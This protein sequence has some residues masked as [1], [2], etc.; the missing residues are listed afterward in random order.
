MNASLGSVQDIYCFTYNKDYNDF[1]HCVTTSLYKGGLLARV[2]IQDSQKMV[3]FKTIRLRM[4]S[5]ASEIH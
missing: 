2:Q 5:G 3:R 1:D 4:L